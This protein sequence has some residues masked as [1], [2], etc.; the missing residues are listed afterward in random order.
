MRSKIIGTTI[1]MWWCSLCG[2]TTNLQLNTP[3]LKL[4]W[5]RSV[6]PSEAKEPT[7]DEIKVGRMIIICFQAISSS[8]AHLGGRSITK[9][10]KKQYFEFILGHLTRSNLHDVFYNHLTK[11]ANKRMQAHI[12][13]QISW[14]WKELLQWNDRK[15]FFTYSLAFWLARTIC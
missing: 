3:H 9:I 7:D 5:R 11:I 15:G 13:S 12:Q 10:F 1:Y 6:F 4:W 8:P 14:K 2:Q